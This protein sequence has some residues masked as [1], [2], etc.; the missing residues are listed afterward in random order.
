MKFHLGADMVETLLF[1]LVGLLV[2]LV[3][4]GLYMFKTYQ[5]TSNT[6]IALEQR[7]ETAFA[8]IDVH[9]KHR[10]SLIAPLLQ[11]AKN[12]VGYEK[13][14]LDKVI[15]ARR[16]VLSSMS[17]TIKLQAEGNLSAQIGT[18]MANIDKMPELRAMPEFVNLRE[19]LT[20]CENRLTAAR[21]F[22]NLAIEEYNVAMRQF[23]GSYVAQKRRMNSRQ[24]IDLGIERV[25]MDEP[26]SLAM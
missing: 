4:I 23:P 1:I 20:D 8:D 13:E 25:L 16:E 10:H 14:M 5:S 19:E 26:V 24:P 15:E 21:R 22:Y 12:V 17:S 9:L 7:C 11:N 3:L 2:G 6:L 18:L